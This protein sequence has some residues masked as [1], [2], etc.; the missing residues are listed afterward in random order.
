LNQNDRHG[1]A[2]VG[3]EDVMPLP[4]QKEDRSVSGQQKHHKEA[5]ERKEIDQR[6]SLPTDESR[7]ECLSKSKPK[8]RR[9]FTATTDIIKDKSIGHKNNKKH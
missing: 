5:I 6:R 9:T 4:H 8:T 3:K 7:D 1:N 2:C